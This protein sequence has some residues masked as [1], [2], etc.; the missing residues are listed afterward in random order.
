MAGKRSLITRRIAEVTRLLAVAQ[1]GR[2][3]IMISDVCASLP[4][5][6][7]HLDTDTAP[8]Q[9]PARKKVVVLKLEDHSFNAISMLHIVRYGAQNFTEFINTWAVGHSRFLAS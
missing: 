2:A 3:M 5:A 7:G 6:F 9:A 8:S 4:D 1:N